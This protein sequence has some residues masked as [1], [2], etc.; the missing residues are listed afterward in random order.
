MIPTVIILESDKCNCYENAHFIIY[1]MQVHKYMWKVLSKLL[2][3]Q[4]KED[5]DALNFSFN[6]LILLLHIHQ[7]FHIYI[8]QI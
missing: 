2:A 8:F 1:K 3:E 6:P 5:M 4:T 7:D